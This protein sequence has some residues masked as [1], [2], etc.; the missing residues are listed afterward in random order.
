MLIEE[1]KYLFHLPVDKSIFWLYSKPIALVG[2][3]CWRR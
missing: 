1:R 2:L 3:T